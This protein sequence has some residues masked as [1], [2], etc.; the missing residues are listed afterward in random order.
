MSEMWCW[1]QLFVQPEML[2]R[3]PGTSA[4]PASSSASP[5]AAARP[6]DCVT[7]RLQVSAPG[8]RDDVAGELGAGLGHADLGEPVVERRAGR[9]RCRS[10]SAKFWRFV[11]RTSRLKSRWMSASAAELLGRDVAEAGVRH[12]ADRALGDAAHDVGFLPAVVRVGREQLHRDA[13]DACRPW[14]RSASPPAG[15]SPCSLHL[16]GDAARPVAR[17]AQELALL[18]DALAQ[19]VDAHRVDEPLHAGADL[20]V[21]VAVVV[22]RAQARFD[23]RQQVF[24]GGELLERLRRVRVGAETAGDEHL[25]AGL[26]SVPSASVRVVATTPTSLNIAWP[27]SVAQPEKLILNLRGRRC[28]YGWRSRKS[29]GRLRPTA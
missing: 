27:Q 26:R 20:V 25:E 12:R 11:M 21:A 19:L 2:T 15:A 16:L 1:P 5:I 17:G 29:G 24:A 4:R 8:Q 7:A 23:R 3:T 10:R 6:R 9:L 18:D 14:S 28:A 22:E 13:L